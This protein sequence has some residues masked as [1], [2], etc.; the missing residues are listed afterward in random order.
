M[1]RKEYVMCCRTDEVTYCMSEVMRSS[2]AIGW[3]K[4]E[5][6]MCHSVEEMICFSDWMMYYMVTKRCVL[7]AK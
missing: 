1:C 6:A 5:E 7:V 3:L 4:T 2:G